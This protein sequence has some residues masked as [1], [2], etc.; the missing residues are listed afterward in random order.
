MFPL[1]TW[2]DA[3]RET[4]ACVGRYVGFV[5]YDKYSRGMHNPKI[6]IDTVY[7]NGRHWTA[8]Y[9]RDQ[10]VRVT[11][12]CDIDIEFVE[13]RQ[14]LFMKNVANHPGVRDAYDHL[15]DAAKQLNTMV[16]LI[17]NYD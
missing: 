4:P 16:L 8:N 14:Y 10:P 12:W 15:L 13:R 17:S 6:E 1:T 5:E 3:T 11:V 7:W 2:H 9:S